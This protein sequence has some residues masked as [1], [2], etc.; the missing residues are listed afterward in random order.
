MA[1]GIDGK[2]GAPQG[3]AKNLDNPTF[4]LDYQNSHLRHPF[5]TPRP[6]DTTGGEDPYFNSIM[7]SL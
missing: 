3:G 6:P 1:N 4:V 2:A 5:F 7:P